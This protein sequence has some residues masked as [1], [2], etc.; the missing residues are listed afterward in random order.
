MKTRSLKRLSVFGLARFPGGKPHTLFL[1]ALN[2]PNPEV[3][4]MLTRLMRFLEGKPAEAGTAAPERAFDR[5]QVAAAALLVE[6]SRLDADFDAKERNTIKALVA[7]RFALT[8]A[9]AE[10]LI[11]VAERESDEVYSDGMFVKAIATGFSVDERQELLSMLWE[12][13]YAD[14]SLHRFEE[15]MIGRVAG[16]LGLSPEQCEAA[17]RH[18]QAAQG[19]H[20]PEG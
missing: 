18:A 5:R 3:D 9:D 1:K 15:H 4:G 14:G 13:A 7:P 16:Q 12:V 10:A 11:R 17:R 20:D 8:G 19:L 2:D 6:A